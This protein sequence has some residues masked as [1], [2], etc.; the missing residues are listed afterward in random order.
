MSVVATTGLVGTPESAPPETSS[1]V[2][3]ECCE[4][5]LPLGTRARMDRETGVVICVE[6]F[7]A[8]DDR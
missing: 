4:K 8:L 3:C 2:A 6:C 5:P 1:G 7:E